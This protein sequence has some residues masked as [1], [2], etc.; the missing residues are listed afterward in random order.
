MTPQEQRMIDQ[1][2]KESF[3]SSLYAALREKSMEG[4]IINPFVYNKYKAVDGK[5]RFLD[6]EEQIALPE[7]KEEEGAG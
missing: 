3:L 6:E 5:I 2:R 4:L 1:I 7:P